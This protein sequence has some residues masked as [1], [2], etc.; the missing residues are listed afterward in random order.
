MK[1]IDSK[2]ELARIRRVKSNLK[3]KEKEPSLLASLSNEEVLDAIM[4]KQF[5]LGLLEPDLSLENWIPIAGWENS[6]QISNY[7]RIRRTGSNKIKKVRMNSKSYVDVPLFLG[8]ANKY[9]QLHRLVAATFIQNPNNLPEV[10]HK[11]KIRWDCRV[12]N[13]E[14]TTARGNK[15]HG[16]S[17]FAH[18][19]K[20]P[21]I[22]MDLSG[23]IVKEW[24]GISEAAR[25]MKLSSGNL[26]GRCNGVGKTLGGFK[27]KYK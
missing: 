15:S 10:N 7:L 22:Q 1:S 19:Y 3:Y 25:E 16:D 26:V 12:I 23:E 9:P 11:N 13:L 24:P 14:W 21:I 17:I 6:Y 5:V 4:F 20:K 27:W 2:K 18:D 8:S